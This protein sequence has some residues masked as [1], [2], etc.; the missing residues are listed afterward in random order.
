[1]LSVAGLPKSKTMLKN[2]RTRLG[3]FTVSTAD[4]LHGRKD[5]LNGE[6]DNKQCPC[7]ISGEEINEAPAWMI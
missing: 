7:L 3:A 6:L 1:M 4:P 2:Q 5:S